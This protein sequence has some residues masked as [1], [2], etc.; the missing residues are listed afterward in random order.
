MG[1]AKIEK[2]SADGASDRKKASKD[3]AQSLHGL[4][5]LWENN[6]RVRQRLLKTARNCQH[7][8]VAD[9]GE[10]RRHQLP[11]AG[12][13]LGASFGH[14]RSMGLEDVC[15]EV[16]PGSGSEEGGAEASG[17]KYTVFIL[18]M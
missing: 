3:K 4:A 18:W 16:P 8:E 9:A 12:R 11:S 15:S 13:E 10:R 14:Y 7:S 5:K 2:S 1:K 6:D 17:V